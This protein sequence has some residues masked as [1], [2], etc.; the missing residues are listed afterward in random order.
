MIERVKIKK[1]SMIVMRTTAPMQAAQVEEVVA[2]FKAV[3]PGVELLLPG[4]NEIF[5]LEPEE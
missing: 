5:I 1:G 2:K 3:F 4:Q